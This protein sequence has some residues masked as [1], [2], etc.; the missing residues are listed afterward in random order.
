MSQ[1]GLK[2]SKQNVIRTLS[3]C[4]LEIKVIF[5]TIGTFYIFNGREVTYE[6]GESKANENDCLFVEASAKT[7][8]N[9][10][11]LFTKVSSTLPA[12]KKENKQD[13]TFIIP[14]EDPLKESETK[15]SGC[16]C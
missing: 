3:S 2:M 10:K 1:N 15:G 8:N 7:G 16:Y 14:L 4:W 11:H 9:I 13:E 6:E 12:S 5:L